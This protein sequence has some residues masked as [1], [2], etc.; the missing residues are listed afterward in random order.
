M[1]RGWGARR[2][3]SL[4]LPLVAVLLAGCGAPPTARTSFLTSLDLVDMTSRMAESLAR[5][6]IVT[7]RTPQDPEWVVSMYRVVNKT[8]QLIPDGQKWAYLGRLRAQ[9]MQ[10]NFSAAHAIVWVVP[11]ERWPTIAE[12]LRVSGEPPEL[13]LRPTHQLT[14]EFSALT[15]TSGAGRSDTYF[16]SFQL[17]ALD[18]G[19]IVWE[20]GWETKRAVSGRTYD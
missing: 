16:C 4:I 20:D 5:D 12:E 8:N 19:Q 17:V 2:G 14:A 11:P 7:R 10:S 6:P 18:T 3:A 15:I 9:L 13:R 1:N